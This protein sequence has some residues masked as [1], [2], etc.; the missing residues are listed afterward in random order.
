M[1][2]VDITYSINEYDNT[3]E[4][5]YLYFNDN[6]RIKV[7]DKIS[8]F[9]KIVEQINTINREIKKNYEH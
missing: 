8:D 7:C 2:I 5:V 1:N 4:G 3:D 6:T 9:Q